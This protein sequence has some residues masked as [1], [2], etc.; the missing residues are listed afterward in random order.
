MGA[1]SFV[2]KGQGVNIL[3]NIFYGPIINAARGVSYQVNSAVY[4]F[5]SNFMT[6]LTPQITKSYASHDFKR[7]EEL[8]CYGSKFSFFLLLII[9]MPII[10]FTDYI[11]HIWLIT[12]PNHT[13]S[14][15]KLILISSIIE[16]SALPLHYG[17]QATGKIKYYQIVLSIVQIANF[18]IAYYYLYKGYEP[19]TTI[20]IAIILSIVGLFIRLQFLHIMCGFSPITYWHKVLRFMVL[21]TIFCIAIYHLSL[22]ISIKSIFT[23]LASSASLIFINLVILYFVGCSKQ[24]KQIINQYIKKNVYK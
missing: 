7:M 4:G 9:S 23:F 14:F 2:M 11:L 15:V 18:P 1:T 13:E 12:V 8:I 21:V 17:I 16:A 24:E 20:I 3:L 5:S 22:F 19:E 6:A 10:C